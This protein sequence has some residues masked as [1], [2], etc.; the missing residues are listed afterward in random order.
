MS[1]NDLVDVAQGAGDQKKE[2]DKD[3][4]AVHRF[5]ILLEK[6]R[7]FCEVSRSYVDYCRKDEDFGEIRSF[8]Y[9]AQS[10]FLEAHSKTR[11]FLQEA[12]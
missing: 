3:D 1:E 6:I 9:K 8:M 4:L 12:E 11:K 5:V 7:E 2:V 10:V